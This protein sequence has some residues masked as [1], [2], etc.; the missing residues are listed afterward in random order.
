MKSTLL[1]H[2]LREPLL[3]FVVLGGLLFA[4]YGWLQRGAAP[5]ADEIVVTRGHVQ[6]LQAQFQRTRQ[7]PA[8]AEELQGLVDHW[9]REEVFYR[10]GIA[11]GLDRDD[12]IVRRRVAQKVEFIADGATPAEPTVRELQEWLDA[13]PTDYVAEPRYSVR[14]VFFDPQRR[15]VRLQADVAAARRALQ[16]GSPADGDATLLPAT[17]RDA[18]ATEVARTFGDDFARALEALPV[19]TWQGPVHSA[20]GVHLVE[21]T[22]REAGRLATLADVRAAV[23]RDLLQARTRA[24]NEAFYRRLRAKY[25]VRIEAADAAVAPAT[26]VKP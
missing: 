5:A 11:L 6:S 15:G 26:R 1:R 7:R 14:Q 18:R 2:L 4:L 20:Y 19:G 8:T 22:A 10:E 24:A 21:I 13:H 16:R 17:L 9:V 3:H 23:E 12:T 25:T